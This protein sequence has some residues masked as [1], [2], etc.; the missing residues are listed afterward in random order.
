MTDRGLLDVTMLVAALRQDAVHHPAVVAWLGQAR[1]A[2]A[3]VVVL[4]ES[5]VAAARVL[6]NPRI[7]V[8][9]TPVTEAVEAL[10]QLIEA[11]DAE[12]LGAGIDVWAEFADVARARPLTTRMVPDALLVA[13]A[14]VNGASVVTL[15]RGLAEYPGVVVDVLT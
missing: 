11:I 9:P 14:R 3:R 4:A 13:A 12:V 10:D 1:A 8:A 6:S 15:D 7:W 2:G 5:L